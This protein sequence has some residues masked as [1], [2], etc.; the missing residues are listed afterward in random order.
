MQLSKVK[1]K[2]IF[3]I[4]LIATASIAGEGYTY[5]KLPDGLPKGL[6][7]KIKGNYRVIEHNAMNDGWVAYDIKSYVKDSEGIIMKAPIVYYD[8]YG[9]TWTKQTV[10][11]SQHNQ[12]I[13]ELV[14]IIDAKAKLVSSV[15]MTSKPLT[16][17]QAESTIKASLK[18]KIWLIKSFTYK[19]NKGKNSLL[20]CGVNTQVQSDTIRAV[21]YSLNGQIY[22]VN[23]IAKGNTPNFNFTFDVD[24]SDGLRV[25]QSFK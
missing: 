16:V 21:W 1:T 24:I 20:I 22:N 7:E 25:C 12:Y 13:P 19:N 14:T 23:G 4:F 15:S 6:P 9:S 11:E 2:L 10:H 3:L 8:H 5:N 18:N 17:Q